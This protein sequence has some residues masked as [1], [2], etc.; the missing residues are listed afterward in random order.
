MAWG[1]REWASEVF[2]PPDYK[3]IQFG[4]P[5]IAVIDF[6]FTAIAPRCG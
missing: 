1:I 3:E 2:F 5:P 4:V 6:A